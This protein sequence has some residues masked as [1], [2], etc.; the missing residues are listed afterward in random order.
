MALLEILQSS[1]VPAI[2]LSGAGLIS[3]S[4]QNRYGRVIDRIRTFH[5]ETLRKDK[6]SKFA[7]E[8]LDILIRR[9]RLLRNSMTAMLLCILFAVLT[10][11]LLLF[12]S[13]FSINAF[14]ILLFFFVSLLSLFLAMIFAVI[15]IFIS[16]DAVLKEDEAVRG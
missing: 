12:H 16:Y 9:G 7:E 2:I 5:Y 14:I 6:T 10:T 15:E 4:L 1:L 13:M 11:I 3:L 8:Q